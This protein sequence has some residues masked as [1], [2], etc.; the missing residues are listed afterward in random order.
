[1]SEIVNIKVKAD[2]GGAVKDI[3]KVG[4]AIEDTGKKTQ[5]TT[6]DVSEM[7]NQL[8]TVSGGA[9]T[10]FKALT[11]TLGSVTKGFKTL[12]GAIISSGLGALVLVIG[13]VAAAFTS[14]EEGQNKFS[15]IMM[16]IGVVTPICKI[17]SLKS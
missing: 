15:K 12:K 11:S 7:G 14:S 9:I 1:M 17:S 3:D 6:A 5:E 10:K 13:S 4:A 16:Q 8:D 2:T